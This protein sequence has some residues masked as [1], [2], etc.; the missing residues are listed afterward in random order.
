MRIFLLTLLTALVVAPAQ[1]S[2]ASIGCDVDAGPY[3]PA[4]HDQTVVSSTDWQKGAPLG[5][6][7]IPLVGTDVDAFEYSVD[8][9]APVVVNAASSSATI[10]GEGEFRFRHRA[11]VKADAGPDGGL[12]TNWVEETV[13]IDSGRPANETPVIT[14]E[15]RKGPAFFPVR[16]TDVISP[17]HAEW[18]VVANGLSGP[19]PW[20]TTDTAL[21]DGTGRYTL[22]TRAVDSAGNES[23]VPLTVDIDNDPPVDTTE[24]AP[25]DWQPHPVDL[26]VD[27]TDAHSGVD[28]VE[29][30]IDAQDPSSARSG[31]DGTIVRIGTQGEHVLRT[32]VVDEVGN[33]FVWRT[34]AV[35]I[36]MAGPTD[37]TDVATTWYTTP[38]V[39]IDITGTDNV[40]RDLALIEWRLDGQPG[41]KVVNPVDSTVPVT[42]SGDGKHVLEVSMTDVDG[43]VLPLHKHLVNIDTVIPID[44]TETAAGWL[45]Y[46]SKNFIVRG[47]DTHSEI[48]RV[49]WRIDGGNLQSAT[50]DH[51]DVTV[52]GDGIHKLETRVI[53]NA[54]KASAWVLRT[55]KLDASAPTNRT[56]IAPTGWR[57]ANYLVTL[58]G[59][60]ALS[61]VAGVS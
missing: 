45:P 55:I 20:N 5:S 32:R 34:Q 30:Q 47:T 56:P 61:G 19:F 21:V 37:T 13:R 53:D 15:W 52:A 42:I 50:S 7:K 2:A 16:A 41:G 26:T 17:A 22:N 38:T 49:E 48:Q 14:S 28:H 39:D 9:G 3:A 11:R 57:N 35:R 60:D 1:A 54:G 43:H 12:W 6:V 23:Q 25:E 46:S 58:N 24:K 10:T 51:H 31:P 27:G 4:S 18:Q 36:N 33:A 44:L 8:C 59:A 29:W 40:G